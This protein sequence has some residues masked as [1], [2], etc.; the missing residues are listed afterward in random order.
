MLSA[1]AIF[2]LAGFLCNAWHP[3]W[4]VFPV[5]SIVCG[6]IKTCLELKNNSVITSRSKVGKANINTYCFDK[7]LL[8]ICLFFRV[9][10]LGILRFLHIQKKAAQVWFLSYQA[11]FIILIVTYLFPI[12]FESNIIFI[13]HAY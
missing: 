2:L 11:A 7:A 6:I 3:A 4:V 10:V 8:I 12:E 9:K 5:G 13:T 1:T